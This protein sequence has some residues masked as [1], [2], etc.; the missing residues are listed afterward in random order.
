M[1]GKEWKGVQVNQCIF[2][3]KVVGDPDIVPTAEG[4]FIFLTLRTYSAAKDATGQWVE[5]A[6][7]VPLM[8]EPGAF[9]AR[10]VENYVK[11]GRE[12]YVTCAYKNWLDDQGAQQHK[13]VIT[14]VK[15][16]S[17]PY[18]GPDNNQNNPVLPP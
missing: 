7:D 10:A 5:T 14:N 9:S 17:K 13:M 18:E 16:G 12:L 2:M 6:L 8:V 11:D 3:G 1:A 15:L 4:N